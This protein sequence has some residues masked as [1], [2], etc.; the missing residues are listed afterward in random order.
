MFYLLLTRKIIY[1][2]PG[3]YSIEL[4][5]AAG[6]IGCAGGE[7]KSDGGNG[8][9]IK[10][11]FN[12]PSRTKV[13]FDVGT[14]PN[15]N[16]RKKNN[17]GLP[18]GG[19]GG[20]DLGF[21]GNG[22]DNP[23]GG[24]GLTGMSFDGSSYVMIAGAG[25]GGAYTVNGSPAGGCFTYDYMQRSRCNEYYYKVVD[26]FGSLEKKTDN[27]YRTSSHYGGNG[28]E[29]SRIPGAG[30][31]AGWFGGI[32]G[33]IATNPYYPACGI[34]GLSG[35]DYKNEYFKELVSFTD[36][37]SSGND[38][39]GS[40]K[41]LLLFTCPSGCYDCSS[42][43]SCTRC[44]SGKVK[45]ADKCYNF[46]S[47]AADNLYQ[48]GSICYKCDKSCKTCD[49]KYN[50]CTS[51]FKGMIVMNGGCISMKT[52]IPNYGTTQR[53]SLLEMASIYIANI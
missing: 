5:G 34:G 16:C 18:Y 39:D 46:C 11:N 37:K 49:K 51:C 45:Y 36:G 14:K 33:K 12:F 13:I 19:N 4:N 7:M 10:A 35:Y 17:G 21:I 42:S 53:L 23:G 3:V 31:G 40:Y 9:T 27:S 22:N 47:E 2:D 20:K 29:T 41:Y 38:G 25:S 15:T 28:S 26:N 1:L 50:N 52:Y 32:A 48:S 30:G 44:K 24:G 43:T 6:G 8:A